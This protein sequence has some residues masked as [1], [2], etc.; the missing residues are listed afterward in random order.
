M[1]VPVVLVRKREEM[2]ERSIV[3]RYGS[4]IIVHVSWSRYTISSHKWVRI[5]H[6]DLSDLVR[7]Y[8]C[9]SDI[10]CLEHCS[11]ECNHICAQQL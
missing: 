2:Q 6:R 8:Y 3:S 10:F 4:Y 11:G 7:Y 1:V 5:D 9:V